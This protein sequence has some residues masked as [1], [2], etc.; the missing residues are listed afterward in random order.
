[1]IPSSR[2]GHSRSQ[3]PD[4]QTHT[5]RRLAVAGLTGILLLAISSAAVP[6]EQQSAPAPQ[7]PQFRNSQ[8]PPILDETTHRSTGGGFY[9][10]TEGLTNV[11][12]GS[13][14][15]D[16]VGVSQA[17]LFRN[18]TFPY[19]NIIS[20][21]P[22]G[23]T[24]RSENLEAGFKLNLPAVTGGLPWTQR[25]FEPQ[26]ADL[27]LGPFYF[28]L[29]A[30]EAA[31][32]YSDNINL[33]PDH[34]EADTIGIVSATV[35][36]VAQVTES[37]RI[38]T[39]GT[40]VY[41][42]TEGKAGIAG[43]GLTDIYNF[44]LAAG[45]LAH[46]QISWDTDIGGWHVVFTD[47]F[48]V[49]QAIYSNEIRSDNVLFEGSQFDDE[50]RAGR[51]VLRPNE[52]AV[53]R[54]ADNRDNEHEF[55]TDQVAF[56]NLV[57]AEAERLQPGSILLKAR[58]Y[59]ED[60]WYNQGNRGQPSLREG[61]TISVLSQ[62]ENMRFKPYFIYDLYHTD[63]DDDLQHIFRVGAF[64]PITDQLYL[65]AEVGYYTG[66]QA[67]NGGLW[68]VQ[69]DHTAGP[70]TQQ[71]LIYARTFNYF[72]DEVDELVGYNLRQI[73]GPRLY[74]DG[75]AYRVRA[76]EFFDDSSEDSTRNEWR[77]GVR[78]TYNIGPKTTLRL[79][80]Q[81]ASIDPDNTEAWTGRLELGYN[82]TDTLLLHFAYQH[83]KSTSDNVSFNYTENLFF[84]SLT[85]YFE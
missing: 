52:G 28:K 75:Y 84:L 45:P 7:R 46:A 68:R 73:L 27:K 33:T 30:V 39:S 57:S 56:S 8:P 38:A 22:I 36:V 81:Y 59:H 77:L 13:F 47:D 2:Q 17:T 64:G 61:A 66:G 6:T 48:Q 1:M 12:P 53:F 67:G 44:G 55:R 72:H 3:S 34:E 20:P 19:G 54:N 85:K 15:P 79:T 24:L 9:T 4:K 50:A 32:L 58:V 71:S 40:F 41:L 82:F 70:Y 35:D 49:L 14:Q 60:L 26:D 63:Q 23:P 51:Y 65:F 80:G 37:F 5:S 16:R 83:Q 21:P 62:R 29:R 11:P 69:L 76:Q 18:T 42:P 10:G 78:F 74:F 31:A 25:A 43:F